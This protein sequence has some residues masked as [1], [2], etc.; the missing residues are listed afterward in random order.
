M[1]KSHWWWVVALSVA[2]PIAAQGAEGGGKILGSVAGYRTDETGKTAVRVEGPGVFERVPLDPSGRFETG[3]LA[4]GDYGLWIESDRYPPVMKPRIAVQPSQPSV[5]AEL[6]MVEPL[7]LEGKVVDARSGAGLAHTRVV[8]QWMA[9]PLLEPKG[10]ALQ[11][12]LVTTDAAGVFVCAKVIPGTYRV[13]GVHPQYRAG[14]SITAQVPEGGSGPAPLVLSMKSRSAWQAALEPL[15]AIEGR[16]TAASHAPPRPI[17]VFVVDAQGRAVNGRVTE[18]DGTYR[19]RELPPA[20]YT[21][22]V[23]HLGLD[24]FTLPAAARERRV[25]L[26]AR[27]TVQGVNFNFVPLT[28]LRGTVRAAQGPPLPDSLAAVQERQAEDPLLAVSDDQGRYAFD[29]V[30]QGRWSLEVHRPEYLPERREVPLKT[31]EQAIQDVVLTKHSDGAIHGEVRSLK[32]AP[33]PGITVVAMLDAAQA[34]H[35]GPV[36]SGPDGRFQ[37]THLLEG[38]YAVEALGEYGVAVASPVIVRAH[39]VTAGVVLAPPMTAEE[40]LAADPA[41]Q[42]I[43]SFV[44]R[45]EQ[46]IHDPVALRRMGGPATRAPPAGGRVDGVVVDAQGRPVAGAIV[47]LLDARQAPT[48]DVMAQTAPD[49]RFAMEGI[50]DGSYSLQAGAEPARRT[51]PEPVTITAGKADRTIRL[52]LP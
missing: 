17:A 33:L 10:L 44:A 34:H 19:I 5:P 46:T 38:T 4:P 40:R 1:N 42:Q 43:A 21:V 6:M 3:D 47:V 12:Q 45:M 29:E 48:L 2:G 51:H 36:T 52:T 11:H 9:S 26:G 30:T 39:R 7:R 32:G 15:A 28:T 49:G 25:V 31:G 16:V 27:Q 8:I 37:L 22:R 50:P 20:T 24:G 18:A 14:A 13:M 23:N 41:F 35:A